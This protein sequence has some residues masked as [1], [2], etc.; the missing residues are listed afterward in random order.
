MN[1]TETAAPA[2][3]AKVTSVKAISDGSGYFYMVKPH[4]INV[5]PGF[6]TRLD[7]EAA[8][9]KHEM[10][11][12]S[13]MANGVL[14]PLHVLIISGTLYVTNGH[15]RLAASL[16]AVK[17]GWDCGPG[18]KVIP[19]NTNVLKDENERDLI[20]Y[21]RNDSVPLEQLEKG[22]LFKRM[23]DRGDFTMEKIAERTG[24]AIPT[25]SRLIMLANAPEEIRQGVIDGAWSSTVAIDAVRDHGGNAFAILTKAQEIATEEK[26]AKPEKVPAGGLKISLPA[27]S[28]AV[29]M[30]GKKPTAAPPVVKVTGK[31]T[32]QAA[33][34]A[35]NVLSGALKA[36]K[37]EE[38]LD[39]LVAALDQ[40]E[41]L[42][43]VLPHNYRSWEEAIAAAKDI[44]MGKMP[45]APSNTKPKTAKVA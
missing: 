14:E 20:I 25:V 19:E 37:I 23:Y 36:K 40:C 8:R 6:N 16:E 32:A 10:L 11:V 12:K 7:T 43:E 22:I 15:R 45:K 1:A 28:P 9:I 3:P 26:A 27:G 17:R 42:P 34:D 24:E 18:I 13:I 30:P 44:L 21:T 5:L 4:L 33:A 38:M 41:R 29:T 31:H 35:T 2:A 39:T